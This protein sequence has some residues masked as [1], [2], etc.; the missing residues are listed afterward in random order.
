MNIINKFLKIKKNTRFLPKKKTHPKLNKTEISSLA[1][2]EFKVIVIKFLRFEGRMGEL[3]ENFK[4]EIENMEK[5]PTAL[6]TMI[7]QTKKTPEGIKSKLEGTENN[8]SNL[9]NKI[10]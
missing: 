7:T 10:V 1:D 4:E 9:E 2:K 8:I 3:S 6:R 5:E